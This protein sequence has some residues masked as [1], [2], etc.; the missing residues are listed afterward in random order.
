M[1]DFQ[2]ELVTSIQPLLTSLDGTLNRLVPGSEF[3]DAV[4]DLV[5]G[6]NG[7]VGG[8]SDGRLGLMISCRLK[9]YGHDPKR[10]NNE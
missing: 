10:I 8:L 4:E 2:G 6:V 1:A 7:E 5:K 9:I 3:V